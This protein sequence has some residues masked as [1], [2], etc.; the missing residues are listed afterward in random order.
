MNPS[1]NLQMKMEDI[2]ALTNY[3]TEIQEIQKS[4]AT[5]PTPFLITELKV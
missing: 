3:N 1:K 2:S 5:I 4:R